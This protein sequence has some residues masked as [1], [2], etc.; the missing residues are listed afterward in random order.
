MMMLKEKEEKNIMMMMMEEE[1]RGRR[2]YRVSQK[3]LDTI[4]ATR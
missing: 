1:G 3:P 2:I 4:K